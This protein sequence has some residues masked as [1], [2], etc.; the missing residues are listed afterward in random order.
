MQIDP[1]KET[2][3]QGILQGGTWDMIQF[4]A[5]SL[6]VEVSLFKLA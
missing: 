1:Q 4:L 5:P 6:G 2:L 3:Q